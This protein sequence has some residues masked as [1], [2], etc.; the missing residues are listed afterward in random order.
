MDGTLAGDNASRQGAVVH[1]DVSAGVDA[2][3]VRA[4][5]PVS[6]TNRNQP[7]LGL[8]AP[9]V[10]RG[11]GSGLVSRQINAFIT[12][13]TCVSQRGAIHL[14]LNVQAFDRPPLLLMARS[15]TRSSAPPA[16][17]SGR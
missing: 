4:T 14:Q 1:V 9:T 12:G 11:A 5:L 10:R 3:C 7:E 15:V 8:L 13:K 17:S 2:S 6:N 16:L